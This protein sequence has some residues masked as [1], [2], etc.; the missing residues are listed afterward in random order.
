METELLTRCERFFSGLKCGNCGINWNSQ[1]EIGICMH[2]LGNWA[3]DP[4]YIRLIRYSADDSTSVHAIRKSDRGI[5]P[6]ECIEACF[7]L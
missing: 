6:S 7:N 5:V 1:K 4:C 3:L 2:G